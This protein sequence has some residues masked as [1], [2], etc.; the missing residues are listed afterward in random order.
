MRKLIVS[1][2]VATMMFVFVSCGAMASAVEDEKLSGD[3]DKAQTDN[4]EVADNNE[5]VDNEVVDNEVA[6]N[7]EPVDNDELAADDTV[8]DETIADNEITDETTTDNEA[9]ENEVVDQDQVT[10]E[11]VI[12]EDTATDSEESDDATVID[13]SPDTDVEMAM[14]ILS[15][16]TMEESLQEGDKSNYVYIGIN[17]DEK[18]IDDYVIVKYVI[19]P[20]GTDTASGIDY[21]IECNNTSYCFD[22]NQVALHPNYHGDFMSL[23]V[24][25]YND[26][27]V[28]GPESITVQIFI[29]GGANQVEMGQS[30]VTLWI[31]DNNS[32][33]D[34][35]DD[36]VENDDAVVVDETPDVDSVEEADVT[37]EGTIDVEETS[38]T[39]EVAA[40]KTV[41]IFC[42]AGIAGGCGEPEKY[43][44]DL[45]VD[46]GQEFHCQAF[47][48]RPALNDMTVNGRAMVSGSY[49]AD[50]DPSVWTFQAGN[51]RS[52]PVSIV[53]S[54]AGSMTISTY[55][56]DSGVFGGS[57]EI[58]M[59]C[60]V[61]ATAENSAAVS[62]EPVIQNPV[63]Y[64]SCKDK[65]IL[66]ELTPGN[67]ILGWNDGSG[68]Q[69]FSYRNDLDIIIWYRSVGVCSITSS[70]PM[71]AKGEG[72]TAGKEV[73]NVKCVDNNLDS[74]DP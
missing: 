5:P 23:W 68:D 70:E 61:Y 54:T 28:E 51:K 14:P 53:F 36:S 7:N 26:G 8:T 35:P 67:R 31:Y 37:D 25:T 73:H 74:C 20:D 10:E 38:D 9:V 45:V 40:P 21:K 39:D 24:E 69:A 30:K 58:Y 65:V 57:V 41:G 42:Y 48:D 27:I 13:E 50:N 43:G 60:G 18:D 15:I 47:L 33:D 29:I 56:Y 62:V 55:D 66:T 52:V 34:L 19:N 2:A 46:I 44:T 3:T 59:G 1:V 4:S 6:D 11:E 12:D 17:V 16:S 63:I 72:L 71:N 32:D 49:T 22:S 64:E